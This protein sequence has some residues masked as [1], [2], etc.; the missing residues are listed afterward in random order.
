MLINDSSR[1][2]IGVFID[3]NFF[4]QVNSYYAFH[5]QS[6][7]RINVRGLF[8]FIEK[9]ISEKEGAPLERTKIV[10]SHF[11]RMRVSA[12]EAQNRGNLLYYDRV[13]E[14]VLSW[15]AIT[16]HFL[17][18]KFGSNK[19][20][21]K[22]IDV[23]IALEAYEQA[24]LKKLDVVVLIASDVTFTPLIRKLNAMGV[25]VMLLTWAYEYTDRDGMNYSQGLWPELLQ[26]CSYPMLM[27]NII[28]E[29]LAA[30]N[31]DVKSLFVKPATVT[32]QDDQDDDTEKLESEVFLLKNNY[33]FIRHHPAN[34]FF[35]QND[36]LET[37]IDE[38]QI[39]DSV[40][41]SIGLNSNGDAVA[42][43]VRLII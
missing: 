21:V 29:G 37:S 7:N 12:N 32:K 41:F 31:A 36:L 42:K 11:F 20:E 28:D 35:H 34:L 40:Q 8:D 17:P 5:H 2:K 19:N 10:D 26:E 9:T 15:Q 25:R 13:L 43:N 18:M 3:G 30:N 16:T 23:H 22:P 24:I 14:D 33:G 38:V 1:R 6:R 39:G 4:I 27:H